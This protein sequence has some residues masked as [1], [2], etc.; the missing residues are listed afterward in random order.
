MGTGEPSLWD[1]LRPMRMSMSSSC[2]PSESELDDSLV[3]MGLLDV[4]FV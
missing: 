3:E 4:A 1:F 2:S